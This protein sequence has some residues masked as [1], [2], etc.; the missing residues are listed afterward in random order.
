MGSGGGGAEYCGKRFRADEH[1]S[2][3]PAPGDARR[4]YEQGVH[5]G[6]PRRSQGGARDRVQGR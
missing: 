5:R 6:V 2:A 1:E 4:V 3:R